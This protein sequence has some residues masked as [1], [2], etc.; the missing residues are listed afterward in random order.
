[1]NLKM[2]KKYNKLLKDHKSNPTVNTLKTALKS[3]IIMALPLC[4]RQQKLIKRLRITVSAAF[5]L[6]TK[7]T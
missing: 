1:M 5:K 2:R 6:V 4:K 3:T 7:T